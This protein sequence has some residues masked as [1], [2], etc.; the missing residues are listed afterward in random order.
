MGKKIIC[1]IAVL[2]MAL[3]FAACSGNTT[4]AS[5]NGADMNG[6][7]VAATKDYV[8]FING[9]ES[10]STTYKTGKVTKGALMRVAKSKFGSDNTSDYET[11]VSK[12][13]VSDDTTAGFYISGDYVYY[14]VPSTENDRKGETKKDQL[15]FFR[16]KLDASSTSSKISDKDFSHD[17]KFRF[18]ANDNEVYLVVYSTNIYVYDAVNGGEIMNTEDTKYA[19]LQ[20][21]ARRGTVQ[22]VMFD[23]DNATPV[24][25]YT[26]KPIDVSRWQDETSATA[27]NYYDVHKITLGGGKATDVISINGFGSTT[28]PDNPELS[29]VI[30]DE[31]MIGLTFDLLRHKD[32][33]LFY[34]QTSL[35]TNVSSVIY[36]TMDDKTGVRTVVTYATPKTTA[37]FADTVTIRSISENKVETMYVDSTLGLVKFDSSKAGDESAD[38]DFG[39]NVISDKEDLKTAT[40]RFLSQE[41]DV[42]YLYYTNSD[43]NYYKISLTALEAGEETEALR[44]NTLSLNTSWYIP[45]VVNVNGKYFFVCVYSD[46]AY[47]SYVYAIDMSEIEKGVKAVKEEKGDGFAESDYYSYDKKNEEDAVKLGK[48]L[49]ILA[50]ADVETDSTTTK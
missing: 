14:A 13:I 12:L 40:I 47:K 38:S 50:E 24:V 29:D 10:Y 17:A 9:V 16:T 27:E 49:G 44:I 26:Y 1:L 4:I 15:L 21:K 36:K 43:G 37:A 3:G 7:F 18:I 32:G 46:S 45:E 22:E 23:E 34:S 5:D 41:G 30:E 33:K 39:V 42:E 48:K 35:N 8:Y 19:D 28:K 20:N 31:E 6:G 11:V 25:Y 2:C